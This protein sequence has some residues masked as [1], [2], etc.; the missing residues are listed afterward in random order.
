M[1]QGAQGLLRR[2]AVGMATFEFG[3]ADIDAR[4]YFRDFYY[5][6]MDH[7]ME[8]FRITPSGY[9]SRVARYSEFSEQFRTTNFVAIRSKSSS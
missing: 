2:G 4:V 8:V 1:F 9:L 3:G 7:A 6:F 5:F